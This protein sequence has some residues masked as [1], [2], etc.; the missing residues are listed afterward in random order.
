MHEHEHRIKRVEASCVGSSTYG[1][2]IRTHYG[3]NAFFFISSSIFSSSYERKK[4]RRRHKRFLR[5]L[6]AQIREASSPL[7]VCC[8]R[9]HGFC[10][11]LLAFSNRLAKVTFSSS[12]V[13]LCSAHALYVRYV[14][15]GE[16]GVKDGHTKEHKWC[17]THRQPGRQAG[18][19]AARPAARQAAPGCNFLKDQ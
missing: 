1:S 18:R 15:V 8:L 6:A 5:S 17:L 16:E 7:S 3:A 19:Q 9:A 14:R 10:I 13:P 4:D 11:N 2:Y 12:L